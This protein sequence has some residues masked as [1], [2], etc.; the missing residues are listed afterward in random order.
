LQ[1]PYCGTQDQNALA[2]FTDDK[3]LYRLYV[4][5]QCKHYLKAID[6][7]QA[8]AEVLFPLERFYTVDM[9]RQAQEQGY[10]P[11]LVRN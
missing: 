6:L 9:D 11:S 7:R 8:E 5:E 4:C 1:C 3:G 2:Y 10:K